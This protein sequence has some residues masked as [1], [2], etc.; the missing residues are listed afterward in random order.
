MSL[1]LAL[2]SSLSNATRT[3][4]VSYSILNSASSN[5]AISYRVLNSTQSNLLISYSVAGAILADGSYYIFNRKRIR[6]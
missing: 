3:L 4:D 1:L 2:S 6:R 5:L